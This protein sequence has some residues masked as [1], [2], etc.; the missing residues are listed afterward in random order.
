MTLSDRPAVSLEEL[1]RLARAA[2]DA[3]DELIAAWAEMPLS[4]RFYAAVEASRKAREAL[5]AALSPSTVLHLI[6]QARDGARLQQLSDAFSGAD[7]A[8]EQYPGMTVLHF[9]FPHL[10]VSADLRQ[11]LD[12]AGVRSPSTEPADAV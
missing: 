11:T 9:A 12:R 2:D 7:F 6:E 4:D 8:D 1:E 5:N 3:S 10:T